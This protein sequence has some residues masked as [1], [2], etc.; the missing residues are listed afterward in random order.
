MAQDTIPNPGPFDE[1]YFFIGSDDL[2]KFKGYVQADMYLPVGPSPAFSEFLIRRARLAATG[3]FQEKFRYMLYARFDKGKAAL[4]EAFIESRHLSFAKLRVGQF[5]VPFSLANLTSSS[6][7]DLLNRSLVID[8]FAPDYDIGVMLFGK[9]WQE[10]FDYAI[11]VFNGRALNQSENNPA[12]D[13]I[14]RLVV[15]PFTTS[16]LAFLQ[17]LY[18]GMSASSGYRE[19][20]L[21]NKSYQ[22]TIGTS[23]LSFGDQVQLEGKMQRLGTDLEW[24]S[25]RASLKAEYLQAAF[26]KLQQKEK[27]Y[28]A[29]AEGFYTTLTY[30]LS[31]EEKGEN[32]TVKPKNN[33]NPEQGTWG[34]FEV[35]SRYEQLQFPSPALRDGLALGT[36]K[37]QAFTAGLNWYPNDDIKLAMN[38]QHFYYPQ[39]LKTENKVLQ[40]E[41]ALLLRFQYQF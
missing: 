21:S 36:S 22:T 38:F 39:S 11:G 6:Q 8:N 37:V 15:A 25:G 24:I 19:D 1:G 14:A 17:N 33:L 30:F 27:M 16:S 2:L 20:D 12:K 3:Y 35:V 4:N 28:H 26:Q 41:N 34:A 7:L 29:T 40:K 5:K 13:I 18:L 31:G 23:F 10:H 9:F 32:S